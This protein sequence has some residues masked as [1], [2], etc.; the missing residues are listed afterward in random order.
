ML[1]SAPELHVSAGVYG[2]M[3]QKFGTHAAA[4]AYL[5]FILLYMPCVSTIAVIRKEL[6]AAW[7]WFS[8]LWSVGLAYGLS[9]ITYQ[10]L[11]WRD[12]PHMSIMWVGAVVLVF[13]GGYGMLWFYSRSLRTP[14]YVMGRQGNEQKGAL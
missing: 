10:I 5:V 4:F 3:N 11:T 7:A 9:T 6:N 13:L 14:S 2:V 12:H 1:A 8:V